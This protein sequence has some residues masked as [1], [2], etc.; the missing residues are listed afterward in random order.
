VRRRARAQRLRGVA[1]ESRAKC[2][3]AARAARRGAAALAEAPRA[4]VMSGS[5]GHRR[6]NGE[7]VKQ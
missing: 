3:G 5:G 7:T 2:R 1:G 4:L 6:E